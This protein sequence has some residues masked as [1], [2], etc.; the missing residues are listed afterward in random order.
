[1]RAAQYAALLSILP[2]LLAGQASPY[3]PLDD[4]RLPAFELLVA[5]GEL[6]D[7]SPLVRPFRVSDALA[8]LQQADTAGAPSRRL[9]QELRAAWVQD[10]AETVWSFEARVGADAYTDGRRDPLRPS[11]PGGAASYGELRGEGRFGPFLVVSRPAVE[12]RL[13][14]DPD[15]RGRRGLTV[16]GRMA[17]SYVGGQWRYGRIFLGAID[18]QWGPAG[19]QGIPISANALPRNEFAFEIGTDRI[20]L[21][22]HAAQLTDRINSADSTGPAIHRYWFIHRLA[23]RPS[24]R[25]SIALWETSVISGAG[26]NFDA[27]WRDPAAVLLLSNIYGLGHGEGNVAVGADVTWWARRRLRLEGQVLLDDV[28]Y[29]ESGTDDRTPSRFAFTVAGSGPAGGTGSWKLLYSLASSLAF[30]TYNSDEV[31]ADAGVGLGRASPSRDQLSLFYSRPISSG[32]V[33]APELTVRRQGA[34]SLTDT[35]PDSSIASGYPVVFVGPT[36][37]TLRAALGVSGAQGPF[38][39][40]ADLGLHYVTNADHQEGEDELRPVG[41]IRF[42][43]GLGTG[44]RVR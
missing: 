19:I 42:T 16:V 28:N 1:M 3:L 15:W 14:D 6:R 23:L 39:A 38:R 37:R 32:W 4:P 24:E 40:T 12:P 9:I 7:P 26:R 11:G 34:R 33:V 35:W 5:R 8:S 13:N 43:F 22:A 41:R 36:E 44:G 30:Q 17:E 18:R 27:R 25:L 20:R 10:T 2:G 29:P 31:Y 21:S